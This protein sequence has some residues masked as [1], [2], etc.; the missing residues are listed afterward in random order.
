MAG[1]NRGS[2]AADRAPGG[3]RARGSAGTIDSLADIARKQTSCEAWNER[4]PKATRLD[5]G[6]TPP[7]DSLF[8]IAFG[9]VGPRRPIPVTLGIQ[10]Q[11]GGKGSAPHITPEFVRAIADYLRM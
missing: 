3:P 4:H 8:V 11:R 2:R 10:L 6:K 1:R 9:V 7:D 5:C